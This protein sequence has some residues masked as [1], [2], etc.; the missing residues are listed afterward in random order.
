MYKLSVTNATNRVVLWSLDGTADGE[1][2]GRFETHRQ[3]SA[4]TD[5][6][7][8]L[9]PEWSRRTTGGVLTK[10]RRCLLDVLRFSSL[11]LAGVST[12][13]G[14][15]AV[16]GSTV[17]EQLSSPTLTHRSTQIN[18]HCI[19]FDDGPGSVGVCGMRGLVRVRIRRPEAGAG[20]VRARQC[21]GPALLWCTQAAQ[22]RA[23][24][25]ASCDLPPFQESAP[26]LARV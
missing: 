13:S 24:C 4:T 18:G 25:S 19:S 16:I 14:C 9:I 8:L 15:Y 11:M 12:R 17:R 23:L 22:P 3:S 20:T 5:D 6:F 2:I 7:C 26:S 21:A 1:E 10:G